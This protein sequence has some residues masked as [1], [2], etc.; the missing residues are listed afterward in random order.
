LVYGKATSEKRFYNRMLSKLMLYYKY[1]QSNLALTLFG[2]VLANIYHQW[3][4]LMGK[5]IIKIFL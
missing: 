1:A 2:H 4:K 5:C 3:A